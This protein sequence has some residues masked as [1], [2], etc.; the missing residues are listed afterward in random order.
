MRCV[1]VAWKRILLR[2]G[3]LHKKG[4]YEAF[5]QLRIHLGKCRT[6]RSFA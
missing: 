5:T 2:G 1:V 4:Y 3:M 6:W